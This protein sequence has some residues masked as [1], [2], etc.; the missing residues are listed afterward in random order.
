MQ[1]NKNEKSD[2]D[3]R[4]IPHAAYMQLKNM[5]AEEREEHYQRM[6]IP[7]N[8]KRKR[9]YFRSI[10]L[11]TPCVLKYFKPYHVFVHDNPDYGGL[12]DSL[13]KFQEVIFQKL[14]DDPEI[15]I[16]GTQKRL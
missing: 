15:G 2:K 8:I 4:A 14:K 7:T 3:K 10:L 13:T 1:K 12:K 5:P 9:L 11:F 16:H 6:G